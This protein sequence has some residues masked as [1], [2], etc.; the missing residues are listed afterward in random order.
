MVQLAP[1]LDAKST[2]VAELET[3]GDEI[4]ELAAHIHAA[5]W[6]LLARLPYSIDGKA[7]A[8]GSQAVRTG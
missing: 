4:A 2:A 7:G 1:L 8:T 5:T 6:Q 3:L